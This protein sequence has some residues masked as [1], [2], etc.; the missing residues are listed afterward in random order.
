MVAVPSLGVQVPLPSWFSLVE[1]ELERPYPE[2]PPQ[3]VVMAAMPKHR[4]FSDAGPKAKVAELAKDE[5]KPFWL[6]KKVDP[7]K[8]ALSR[9]LAAVI[10]AVCFGVSLRNGASK[11]LDEW[12]GRMQ[13]QFQEAYQLQI[14]SCISWLG[15]ALRVF[16]RTLVADSHTGLTLVEPPG[17]ARQALQGSAKTLS[18][19]KR[20]A[21]RTAVL[22]DLL[23]AEA[24]PDPLMRFLGRLALPKGA[25]LYLPLS[26]LTAREQERLQVDHRGGLLVPP[27]SENHQ[28]LLAGFIILRGLL[29]GLFVSWYRALSQE[30]T[31]SSLR[32][33]TNLQAVA[34]LLLAAVQLRYDCVDDL[35]EVKGLEE[36]VGRQRSRDLRLQVGTPKAKA[37]TRKSAIGSSFLESSAEGEDAASSIPSESPE[38]KIIHGFDPDTVASISERLGTFLAVLAGAPE[39]PMS[40]D[41]AP[42]ATSEH[43]HASEGKTEEMPATHLSEGTSSVAAGTSSVAAGSTTGGSKQAA[44]EPSK[45]PGFWSSII[46]FGRHS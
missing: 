3:E 28:V 5:E 29:S 30:G 10:L 12:A 26:W 18:P 13:L 9:K 24:P 14:G 38:L 20:L 39:F 1:A 21:I 2:W 43:T 11:T 35:Q 19:S 46:P 15:R 7:V 44:A 25:T 33:L 40:K 22:L 41:S 42:V 34:G 45:K 6:E 27:G 31:S 32:A 17:R 16:C 23:E 8:H 36:A 4:P 37:S